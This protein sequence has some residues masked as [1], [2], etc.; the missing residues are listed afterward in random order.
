MWDDKVN[1]HGCSSCQGCLRPDVEVVD[2]LG[3]HERHLAVGVSVDA[4]W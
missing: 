1:D 4:A 2:G 3:A